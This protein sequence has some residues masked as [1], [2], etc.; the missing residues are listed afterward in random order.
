MLNITD[1]IMLKLVNRVVSVNG[2]RTS[3][4]MC[5]KE[6]LALEDVCKKEKITKNQLLGMIEETGKNTLGLT[7]STRLFIIAYF[8]YEAL[9]YIYPKP[10]LRKIIKNSLSD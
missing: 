10:C 1:V 3:M 8:R 5:T 4:R 7:Y 9:G 2:R 6:W